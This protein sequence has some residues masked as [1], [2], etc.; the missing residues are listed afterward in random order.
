VN[1]LTIFHPL[2]LTTKSPYAYPV[3]FVLK[4]AHAN[5]TDPPHPEIEETHAARKLRSELRTVAVRIYLRLTKI[6]CFIATHSAYSLRIGVDGKIKDCT[7]C[8]LVSWILNV[9]I[10]NIT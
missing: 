10:D 2:N 3:H 8:D 6:N 7:L 5:A 4:C 9:K 1:V